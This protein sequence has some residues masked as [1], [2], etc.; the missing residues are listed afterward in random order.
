MSAIPNRPQPEIILQ[1]SVSAFR[2]GA[3]IVSALAI[4]LH[5]LNSASAAP[6]TLH[7]D[8]MT[9]TFADLFDRLGVIRSIQKIVKRSHLS[10]C[11]FSH[12]YGQLIENKFSHNCHEPKRR[13]SP[14]SEVICCPPVD[15]K[16]VSYPPVHVS[17]GVEL[18][19]HIAGVRQLRQ[20]FLRRP[21]HLSNQPRGFA[22][23]FP[24]T[25]PRTTAMAFRWRFWICITVGRGFL[26]SDDPR[27]IA[28]HMHHNTL[29]NVGAHQRFMHLVAKLVPSARGET[30]GEHRLAGNPLLLSK[31]QIVRN[32]ALPSNI[33]RSIFV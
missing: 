18:G 13:L 25:L 2:S 12:R 26:A 29:A 14:L 31:P 24:L 5:R 6:V 28:A 7:D 23:G 21:I 27:R 4:R 9:Q 32:A 10:R 1:S 33:S 8:D 20:G 15:V 3:L 16:L 17:L 30:A 11:H 19:T 22:R